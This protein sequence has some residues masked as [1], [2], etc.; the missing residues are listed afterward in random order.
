[1]PPGRGVLGRKHIL[2]R[3]A[4][5]GLEP[6][7]FGV[8]QGHKDKAARG[9]TKARAAGQSLVL[10]KQWENPTPCYWNKGLL[11]LNFP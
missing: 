4:W 9:D 6:E 5:R 7:P 11:S 10:Q 8:V 2:V 1:M 3:L